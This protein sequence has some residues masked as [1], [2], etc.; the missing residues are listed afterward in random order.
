MVET[1]RKDKKRKTVNDIEKIMGKTEEIKKTTKIGSS[2]YLNI[3]GFADEQSFFRV[4]KEES[5]I[6]TL[7]KLEVGR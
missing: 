7:T 1:F 4:K 6:I 5:G 3:T 2:I